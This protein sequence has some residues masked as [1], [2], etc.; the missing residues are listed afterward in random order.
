M[1]EKPE[2]VPFIR[3]VLQISQPDEL[4]FKLARHATIGDRYSYS[5]FFA[6]VRQVPFNVF[7]GHSFHWTLDKIC[8]ST[9]KRSI[10]PRRGE[11]REGN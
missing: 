9:E 3:R 8:E 7:L 1:S 10:S 2:S 4:W 5:I 11:V 6:R